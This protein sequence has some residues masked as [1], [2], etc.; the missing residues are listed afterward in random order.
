MGHS[1]GE[2]DMHFKEFLRKFEELKA[3]GIITLQ[4]LQN[5]LG[6]KVGE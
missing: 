5:Y 4:D 2:I 6:R 1:K 3:M